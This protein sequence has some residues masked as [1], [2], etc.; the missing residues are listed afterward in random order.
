MAVT[1]GKGV[2]K[3][4][5]V[6]N[7]PIIGAFVKGLVAVALAMAA[8]LGVLGPLVFGVGHLLL[9][10][11]GHR[12]LAAFSQG[13][14]VATKAMVI[15]EGV[16]ARNVIVA[17]ILGPV[18]LGIEKA[19][20]FVGV[21]AVKTGVAI[22]AAFG[23]FAIFAAAAFVAIKV[24]TAWRLAAEEAAKQNDI[25]GDGVSRLLDSAGIVENDLPVAFEAV[26]GS[27]EDV[28]DKNF[29]LIA[30]LKEVKGS[31]G[32]IGASAVLTNIGASLVWKGATPEQAFQLITD[33]GN[34]SGIE[35]NINLEDFTEGVKGAGIAFEGLAAQA[36]GI[37]DFVE[38]IPHPSDII[39]SVGDESGFDKM[40]DNLA[41]T[42]NI[43][44]NIG[45][46]PLMKGELDGIAATLDDADL[47]NELLDATI[48]KMEDMTGKDLGVSLWDIDDVDSFFQAMADI[49]KIAKDSEGKPIFEMPAID[50]DLAKDLDVEAAAQATIDALDAMPPKIEGVITLVGEQG[51]VLQ[52]LWAD[53]DGAF[54]AANDHINESQASITQHLQDQIPV[55]AAYTE[56]LA[57]TS[58]ALAESAAAWSADIKVV[59]EGTAL[60]EENLTPREIKI[61]NEQSIAAQAGFFK[62]HTEAIAQDAKEGTDTAATMFEN[63]K[64]TMSTLGLEDIKIASEIDRIVGEA[65]TILETAMNTAVPAAF[66]IKFNAGKVAM[67]TAVNDYV[68]TLEGIVGADIAGPTITAPTFIGGSTTYTVNVTASNSS[69]PGQSVSRALQTVGAGHRP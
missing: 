12:I 58:S 18:L 51:T 49:E 1:L 9:A 52:Q 64:T 24:F 30:E 50:T 22:V 41:E 20:A 63:L 2:E 62:G 57:L 26:A 10:F 59:S 53:M 8:I 25:F 17:K 36:Q 14:I 69:T 19:L 43:A 6:F 27:I 48:K 32:D 23:A 4:L 34:L 60:L 3:M 61:F 37:A 67:G 7:I 16:M 39:G 46:L 11:V 29:R 35:V 13:I 5:S 66:V 40:V 28:R 56:A 31:L 38:N 45:E 15:L 21:A 54:A 55:F 47:M 42:L 65:D 44:S 33:M 68:T